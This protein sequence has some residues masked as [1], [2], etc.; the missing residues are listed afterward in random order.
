[1]KVLSYSSIKRLLESPQLFLFP[2]PFT[3]KY[4]SLGSLFDAIITG[5]VNDKYV[6]IDFVPPKPQI[7]EYLE[8]TKHCEDEECFKHVHSEM[9]IKKQYDKFILSLPEEYKNL[10]KEN[11][12]IV[13][14]KEE[15]ENVCSIIDYVK[16]EIPEYFQI[17]NDLFQF[18]DVFDYKDL[19][20]RIL[21]DW[22]KID[23]E[24]KDVL[25]IDVKTSGFLPKFE[26]SI[27]KY[28]Y[29]L[30]AHL[31]ML[32]FKLKFPDY[33]VRFEWMVISSTKKEFQII[34]MNSFQEMLGEQ[35]LEEGI[36]RYKF[37]VKHDWWEDRMENYKPF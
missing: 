15:Y 37:H 12:K 22:I 35:M 26:E 24:N 27:T 30:Q 7:K 6:I 25:V 14:S 18:D 13:I 19:K 28:G 10:L 16:E 8:L 31:Y 3:S 21:A 9:N 2:T 1:M 36:E 11:K 33:S 32:Y 20:F 23:H 4:L 34:E 17:E 5:D 29:N